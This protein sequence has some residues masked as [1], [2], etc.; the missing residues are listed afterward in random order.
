M[1]AIPRS[2][3]HIPEWMDVLVHLPEELM[4]R[5]LRRAPAPILR[6]LREEWFWQVHGDQKEP[7]GDWR[8][9][10]VMAGRGFGKTRVG[11]E[12][13]SARARENRAP[14]SRSSERRSTTSSR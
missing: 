1:N 5:L 12:W 10:L 4:L 3:E 6:R 8:V 7:E 2:M 13:I 14:G 11:A 9:W